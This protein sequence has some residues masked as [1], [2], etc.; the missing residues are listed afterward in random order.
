MSWYRFLDLQNSKNFAL[1]RAPRALIV[2][3]RGLPARACRGPGSWLTFGSGFGVMCETQLSPAVG[4][5][6]I[7][8]WQNVS[9]KLISDF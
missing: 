5:I 6:I 2:G 4:N 8:S 3:D 7:F 9:L 1:S